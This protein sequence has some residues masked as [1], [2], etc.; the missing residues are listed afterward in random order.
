MEEHTIH[1]YSLTDRCKFVHTLPRS[2]TL[3]S[4]KRYKRSVMKPLN[5]VNGTS[6]TLSQYLYITGN[7]IS[8]PTIHILTDLTTKYSQSLK[9]QRKA[10]YNKINYML[11]QSKN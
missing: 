9:I 7:K 4:T 1:A 11:G 10:S 5:G 8:L 3:P 6:G 2:H